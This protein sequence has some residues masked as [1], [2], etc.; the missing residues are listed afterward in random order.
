[1]AKVKVTLDKREDHRHKDGRCPLVLRISHKRK[2]RDIPFDIYV[3]ES[4]FNPDK[5]EIKGVVNAV[6]NSKRIQKAYS[7]IDLWL[8]ENKAEIKLWDI[9]KLKDQIE[10]K[11]FK[12]QSEL[13]LF[14]H[15]ADLFTRFRMKGKYSTISSYEDALKIVVKHGMKAK[16]KKDTVI[17]KTLF[18]WNE[19]D[20]KYEVLSEYSIYDK[21]IKAIDKSFAKKLEA[22]MSSRFNSKNTVFIH[23]RSLQSIISDAVDSYDELKGHKP[24]EGIKKVSVP[25]KPVVLTRSEIDKIRKLRH[26]FDKANPKYHVI[27]YF[28]FMFNNMGMN[29]ADLA[30]AKV[31]SFDGERFNY[32]RKKT[33]EE[34]DHFSILQ[35][36]ENLEIIKFYKGKKKGDEYLFPI[37][38]LD[39]S[40]ERIFRVRKQKTKWFNDHFN[41]IASKLEIEKNITT[42]TAR[43]TWTN[44]GLSMGIDI[45][46]IS[47]GLGHANVETTEKHYQQSMQFKLL[48]EMNAWIT[49][50]KQP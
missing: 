10:R 2:T 7:D 28:L 46:K 25:N 24:F 20:E 8:D 50:D 41:E 49:G 48:D 21:P 15:A 38:S 6:R 30:L 39:T 27:N 3:L 36:E 35:N 12:K 40:E 18:S 47:K 11:F 43:D 22:Y 13:N 9:T 32:T 33:E 17:I 42:Y 45:R 19:K 37:I 4:Q 29:F 16:R 44:M 34:G 14:E 26:E 23:L 31:K 1:M 5:R